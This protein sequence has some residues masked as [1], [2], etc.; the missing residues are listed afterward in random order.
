MAEIKKQSSVKRIDR[1][2]LALFVVI[3]TG[4]LIFFFLTLDVAYF[5]NK[6]T[7]SA[8]Y[9]GIQQWFYRD[10]IREQRRIEDEKQMAIISQEN[11]ELKERI[12]KLESL[13]KDEISKTREG[14]YKQTIDI[15]EEFYKM[16]IDTREAFYEQF[17]ESRDFFQGQV[18]ENVK[19]TQKIKEKTI[20][21][22]N[23]HEEIHN[24]LKRD[25]ANL[26]RHA[27]IESER[28]K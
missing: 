5:W 9:L 20:E 1:L 15:R 23:T 8:I 3:I 2:L 4:D 18:Q 16:A 17:T 27:G 28:G 11:K 25:I 22:F 12:T 10:G 6:V 7:L 19:T 14:F 13:L 21:W 24:K 26:L